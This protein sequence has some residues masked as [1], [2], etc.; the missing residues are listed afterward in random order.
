MKSKKLTPRFIGPYQ[1]LRKMGH[2]AYQISLPPFL[3]N[4]H[5]AFHVS[6][7]RKYISNYVIMSD[8]VQSKDNLKFEIM[9]IQ[10]VDKRIKQLRGKQISLLKVIWNEDTGDATWELEEKIRETYPY[11][12]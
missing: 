10:I 9:P 1:I 8:M 12:F 11:L 7:L 4:L 2:A 6:Q 3:S 5:H